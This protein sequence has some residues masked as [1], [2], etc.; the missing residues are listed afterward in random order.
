MNVDGLFLF[1]AAGDKECWMYEV[2]T[3]F[4]PFFSALLLLH[5]R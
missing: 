4:A 5:I 2:E 3:G 1:Q